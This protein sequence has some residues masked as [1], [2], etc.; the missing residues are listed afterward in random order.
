MLS[1]AVRSQNKFYML[2][3][4]SLIENTERSG[5]A[6]PFDFVEDPD[7][8]V[9]EKANIIFTEQIV[10]VNIFDQKKIEE[11]C[12]DRQ[13]H[14]TIHITFNTNGLFR[15]EVSALVSKIINLSRMTYA[16]LFRDEF[17][18]KMMA[19]NHAQLSV[20]ESRVVMLMGQGYDTFNISKILNCSQKTVYTHRRNAIRKLGMLNRLQF[21][22]YTL[23]LK[24]FSYRENI[25][26]C[27]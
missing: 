5:N 27:L 9:S 8:D 23:L 17:F 2:G 6:T 10:I 12:D 15:E 20:T 22:K 21:Y 11:Y 4:M 24:E 1:I 7:S 25:F 16:Q 14:A 13:P 19:R 3:L 18:R 26:L